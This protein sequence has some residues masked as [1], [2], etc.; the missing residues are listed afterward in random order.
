MTPTLTRNGAY[1]C[2]AWKDDTGAR[3]FKNLGRTDELTPRKAAQALTDWVKSDNAP[4]PKGGVSISDALDELIETLDPTHAAKT[5]GVY[6]STVTAWREFANGA[7]AKDIGPMHAE[8]FRAWLTSTPCPMT[9]D[10]QVFRS[11]ATVS[12]HLATARHLFECLAREG[13]IWGNPFADMKIKRGWVE[14]DWVYV[15]EADLPKVLDACPTTDWRRAFAI[16]RLAGL[17]A[18]EIVRLRW[19]DVDRQRGVIQVVPARRYGHAVE[20]TKQAYR[21]VPISPTLAP[22]LV[23]P[24]GE[25]ED[26]P[27]CPSLPL[28]PHRPAR[29]ILKAAGVRVTKPLHSMRK[30]LATDWQG[31][32]PTH[33]AAGFLGHSPEVALKHYQQ[34]TPEWFAKITGSTPTA[35][36][37]VTCHPVNG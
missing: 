25:P 28:Q 36:H 24:E 7:Q 9:G 6:R 11:P 16:A 22:W 5:V 34:I 31:Q 2:A 37:S 1:W 19:S 12:R 3:R 14:R 29:A 15:A 21:L 30:S 27:V 26:G 33:V 4:R 8:K 18:G 17:R 23:R 32:L 13:I 20:T 35:M 10:R